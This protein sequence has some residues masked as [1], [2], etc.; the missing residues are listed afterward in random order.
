MPNLVELPP[1]K[2]GVPG[3]GGAISTA[4]NV[5]FVAASQDN[6]IR[7]FNVTNGKMLW[8]ARLPAGGQAT[9]MTYSIEASN[10]WSL[11]WRTWFI[12]Y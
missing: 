2:I 7:A 12:W 10:M 11:W 4:G 6:Y 8:E 9:P 1:L 3:L 5:M